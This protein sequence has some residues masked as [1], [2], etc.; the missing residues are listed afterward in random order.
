[1]VKLL[2]NK[3]LV[4]PAAAGSLAKESSRFCPEPHWV[5][6]PALRF[7]SPACL[8]LTVGWRAGD[9][10]FLCGGDSSSKR[11]RIQACF[12]KAQA[13]LEGRLNCSRGR[14]Q[15]LV[16]GEDG[17][18]SFLRA[19]GPSV[20]WLLGCLRTMAQTPHEWSFGLCPAAE[21]GVVVTDTFVEQSIFEWTPQ[22]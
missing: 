11:K 1:M 13:R 17:K 22:A 15:G 3:G 9:E 6:W 18:P 19:A 8:A 12:R 7:L 10:W 5:G 20:G 21:P 14:D 2:K 4:L 16:G